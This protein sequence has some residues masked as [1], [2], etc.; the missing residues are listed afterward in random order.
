MYFVKFIPAEQNQSVHH[1]MNTKVFTGPPSVPVGS[2]VFVFEF[3]SS[4]K[5]IDVISV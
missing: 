3:K 5:S 2:E 1:D 4:L